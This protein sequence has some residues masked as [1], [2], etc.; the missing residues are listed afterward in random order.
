MAHPRVHQPCRVLLV[1]D[2]VRDVVDH[3]D[4]RVDDG[5]TATS[6]TDGH[7]VDIKLVTDLHRL[8]LPAENG[9]GLWVGIQRCVGVGLDKGGKPLGISVIRVLMRDQNCR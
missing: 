3:R 1:A 8:P 6:P 7:P 2:E 5:M 9:G 4:L